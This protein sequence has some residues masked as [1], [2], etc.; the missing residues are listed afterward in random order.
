MLMVADKRIQLNSPTATE[1]PP[2]VRDKR[3]GRFTKRQ[4]GKP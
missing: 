1:C 4:K 2:P 3:T